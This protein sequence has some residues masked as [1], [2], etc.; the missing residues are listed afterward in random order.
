M[1]YCLLAPT[2]GGK[3]QMAAMALHEA[4][5]VCLFLSFVHGLPKMYCCPARR[6][7]LFPTYS[8]KQIHAR[9]QTRT[10]THVDTHTN[11][12]THRDAV[13]CAA[14]FRKLTKLFSLLGFAG[15]IPM[16]IYEHCKLLLSI[17]GMSIYMWVSLYVC[18]ALS[19]CF[20]QTDDIDCAVFLLVSFYF[21]FCYLH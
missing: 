9:K 5:I 20:L 19:W 3:W 10:H 8:L 15:W 6:I 17:L 12:H 4:F 21:L 16:L 1:V 2:H 13:A 7:R 18:G 14:N 11:T